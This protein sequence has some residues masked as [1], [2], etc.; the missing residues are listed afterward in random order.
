MSTRGTQVTLHTNVTSL[1]APAAATDGAALV[2]VGGK[3]FY[4]A[5]IDV[6]R[7]GATAFTMEG[8]VTL[9]AYTGGVW[10][11]VEDLETALTGMN[12]TGNGRG[13]HI[14][15]S[16]WWERLAV[17]APNWVFNAGENVSI[18]FRPYSE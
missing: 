2:V 12:L 13:Y 18:F 8:P 15:V 16:P 5:D 11:D 14:V 17:Y 4:E 7:V 10:I 3:S 1:P 6:V 9:R